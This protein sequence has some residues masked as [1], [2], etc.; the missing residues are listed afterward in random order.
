MPTGSDQQPDPDPFTFYVPVAEGIAS[1]S[2]LIVPLHGNAPEGGRLN[3]AIGRFQILEREPDGLVVPDQ[4]P[5]TLDDLMGV[6]LTLSQDFG[7]SISIDEIRDHLR[8]NGVS[9]L[10]WL[11][12]QIAHKADLSVPGRRREETQREMAI[13]L[14]PVRLVHRA[15]DLVTKG[16]RSVTSTQLVLLLA[17]HALDVGSIDVAPLND[18][19]SLVRGL[20]LCLLGLADSLPTT[21]GRTED[22]TLELT[23]NEM[24]YRLQSGIL[25]RWDESYQILFDVAPSMEDHPDFFDLD[26]CVNSAFGMR[27]HDFWCITVAMGIY[28]AGLESP[29]KFP[30][31]G[32]DLKV[33]EHQLG[34]WEE[35]WTIDLEEA[36][37]A[38]ARDL[39]AGTGWA[40]TAFFERPILRVDDETRFTP[41]S[42]FLVEKASPMGMF[43][44]IDRAR[45]INGIEDHQG[46]SRFFGKAIEERGQRIIAEHVGDPSRALDEEA[47]RNSWPP[48]SGQ[49]TCDLLVIYPDAWLACDFVHRSPTR[50]TLA[51][52]DYSDLIDDVQKAVVKKVMQIDGTLDRILASGQLRAPKRILPVV[53]TGAAFPANPLVTKTIDALLEAKDTK[54]IRRLATCRRPIVIDIDELRWLTEAASS[55]AIIIP[56]LLDEWLTSPLGHSSLRN[57]LAT[58][59]RRYLSFDRERWDWYESVRRTLFNLP[60][61]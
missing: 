22:L 52:G 25:E 15:L 9:D 43:W 10:L 7:A 23:R 2:G 42:H 51:T 35:A 12:A 30:L 50:A 20:G 45:K 29:V 4:A 27:L 31:T 59:G 46:W 49:P 54:V 28:S 55:T 13:N 14:L 39:A 19:S 24:F 5:T 16:P 37:E 61:D 17:L 60:G 56:D 34:L 57:W 32:S 38:A 48:K 21:G 3:D 44:L 1:A 33:D 11:L 41:R 26:E 58:D 8:K 6:Y 36:R 47:I 18:I 53:V 40:F